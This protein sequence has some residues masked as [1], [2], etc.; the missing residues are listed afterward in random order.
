MKKINNEDM[1][2][3]SL[4]KYLGDMLKN[5]VE[6]SPEEEQKILLSIYDK[7]KELKNIFSKNYNNLWKELVSRKLCDTQIVR[8]VKYERQEAF[9]KRYLQNNATN[10]KKL[11]NAIDGYKSKDNNKYN[12]IISLLPATLEEFFKLYTNIIKLETEI[13]TLIDKICNSQYWRLVISIAKK[14]VNSSMELSDLIQEGNLGLIYAAKSFDHT[15]G[16]KFSTYATW[17]IRQSINRA[18]A[19]QANTI[20]IP[21]P[22]KELVSKLTKVGNKIRQEQGRE[23]TINDYMREM[24][25]RSPEKIKSIL[26]IMQEPISLSTPIGDDEDTTLEDF[27]EDKNGPNPDVLTADLEKKQEVADVLSKLTERERKVIRYRFGIG[28][29]YPRTLEEVGKMFNV[30]RERIRQI[31]EKAIRRLRHPSRA[32]HLQDYKDELEK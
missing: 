1:S 25:I 32:R 7:R 18:I 22:M 2:V 16:F 4:R 9:D 6:L 5:E 11:V 27:L 13:D 26:Q 8:K 29:G 17:W 23:P 15:R 12:E 31:E 28:V 14:H 3:N 20:R 10:I 19:D 21:V 24:N 30:T